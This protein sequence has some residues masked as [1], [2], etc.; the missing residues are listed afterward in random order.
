MDVAHL[1]SFGNLSYTSL[2]RNPAKLRANEM[3]MAPL[4]LAECA[5]AR[6]VSAIGDAWTLLILREAVYG[7]SRFD[8]IQV[9]LGIPRTVLSDRLNRLVDAGLFERVP[10][11]EPNRRTRQAYTLTQKGLAL[12]PALVAL[13]EW[14]EDHLPGGPSRLRLTHSCGASV[15]SK[16]ICA[17]GHV[18][19]DYSTVTATQ[20][21]SGR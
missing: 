16:L 11:R 3:R 21:D 6:A 4:P 5:L 8:E 13:R 12:L 18:V 14:A 20:D 2:M 1:Q 17:R 7:V 9:D 15:R 10:Y 19:E